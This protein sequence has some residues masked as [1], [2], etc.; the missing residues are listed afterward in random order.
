MRGRSGRAPP[1]RAVAMGST[2]TIRLN[3]AVSFPDRYVL[4]GARTAEGFGRVR[5]ETAQALQNSA[6]LTEKREAAPPA[7]T[8]EE[9]RQIGWFIQALARENSSTAQMQANAAYADLAPALTGKGSSASFIGRLMLMAEQ[10]ETPQALKAL[11]D[12]IKSKD[13]DS[14][15]KKREIANA[16]Y[17]RVE[18]AGALWQPFALTVLRRAKYDLK[19]AKGGGEN[20]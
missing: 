2:V 15:Q 9:T 11:F 8:Q 16:L 20:E 7:L 1:V 13:A 5:L 6:R 3:R 17:A 12:S 14:G 10:A 19:T 4:L 18:A